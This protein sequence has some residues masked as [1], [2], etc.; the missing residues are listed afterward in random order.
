MDE[1]K[2][3]PTLDEIYKLTK[4]NN[5]MLKAMRRDAFVGGVVKFIG[6]VLVFVVIPYIL[7]LYIQPYLN[8]ALHTYNN[9][10]ATTNS[11]QTTTN[12]DFSAIQD[13]FKQFQASKAK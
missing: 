13:F 9:V 1:P 4:E 2:P 6:W 11:V 8:D 7:W 3:V 5:K 10:K 12:A